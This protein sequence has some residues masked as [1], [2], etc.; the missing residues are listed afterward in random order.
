MTNISP[1][2]TY[3]CTYIK[4]DDKFLLYDEITGEKHIR[5]SGRR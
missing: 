2:E 5:I 1:T 4:K 3:K